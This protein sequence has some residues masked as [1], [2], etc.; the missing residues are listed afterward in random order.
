MLTAPTTARTMARACNADDASK[1]SAKR[2][3]RWMVSLAMTDEVRYTCCIA[4]NSSGVGYRKNFT[5]ID[6]TAEQPNAG[7]NLQGGGDK[8]TTY[9][10]ETTIGQLT[11]QHMYT[12]N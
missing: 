4:A 5:G 7:T 8:T 11:T 2:P 6:T 1:Q 10:H 12:Y 3:A 9:V